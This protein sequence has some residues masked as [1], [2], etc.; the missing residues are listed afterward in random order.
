M[1]RARWSEP[2]QSWYQELVA[3]ARD[4]GMLVCEPGSTPA[5][6]GAALTLLFQLI[7]TDK[8]M[9]LWPHGEFTS[10]WADLLVL[11][12]AILQDRPREAQQTMRGTKAVVQVPEYSYRVRLSFPTVEVAYVVA[13][14]M[15]NYA[16]LGR[17]MP[18]AATR[19]RSILGSATLPPR[20]VSTA[21]D[22]S[23]SETDSSENAGEWSTYHSPRLAAAR[24]RKQVASRTKQLAAFTAGEL[25]ADRFKDDSTKPLL[26]LATRL[27]MRC[28]QQ[29]LIE[30]FVSN[31]QSVGC[32]DHFGHDDPTFDRVVKAVPELQDAMAV[33]WQL[34]DQVGGTLVSLFVRKDLLAHL[35]QLNTILRRQTLPGL[36][37]AALRVVCE[38]HPRRVRGER[39]TFGDRRRLCLTPEPAPSVSRPA[40]SARPQAPSS[41]PSWAAVLSAARPVSRPAVSRPA[42]IVTTGLL[43]VPMLLSVSLLLSVPMCG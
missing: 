1:A 5:Q 14:Y 38:A 37:Q 13:C 3:Q 17:E 39:P 41:L 24:Q 22:T 4:S 34:H 19:L 23:V 28:W 15:T 32:G 11:P 27:S 40:A 25:G 26:Q 21:A 7:N 35:P 8:L 10:S 12:S 31:W 18:D 36:Q 30:C 20:A 33:R 29:H 2:Q 43:S 6:R 16:L 9:Q 42:P